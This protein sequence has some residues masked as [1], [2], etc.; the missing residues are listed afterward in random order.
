MTGWHRRTAI[1]AALI[2]LVNACA[3]NTRD[4]PTLQEHAW[5]VYLGAPARVGTPETLATDPQ[6]VWRASIARG[7]TGAAAVTEDVLAIALSDH[8][9]ALLDRSTGAVIWT[10]RVGQALGAGPL[11]SDDRVLV[12]EQGFGGHVHALRLING[13]SFWDVK[14]GDVSAPM[15]LDG[16]ALFLGTIDGTVARIDSHTGHFDWRVRLPGAVRAAPLAGPAG[17][18]VATAAD[19]LFLLDP[20]SGRILVRRATRGTV[21][22]APARADS[23]VVFGTMAGRLEAIDPATLRQRWSLELGE[24][25]VG[26]V[27]IQGGRV[28]AM[29]GRGT[30]AI[31]PL[32]GAPGQRFPLG[33]SARAG[34]TP[35]AQGVVVCSVEGEIVMVDSTGAKQWTAHVQAPV[36]EP[37]LAAGHT[38]I[39]VSVRGDVVTFR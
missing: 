25:I 5:P 1:V 31:V 20:T 34:P 38:L 11:V 32:S 37:V 7:I 36:M 29:T 8:R 26:S 39:A 28:Y 2:G 33:L 19:S 18:L 21:M 22:A 16:P 27:A 35:T 12:A 10:R 17:L 13:F 30:L 15:A 4:G 24:P 14:V 6:P 23:L 3:R 9:V